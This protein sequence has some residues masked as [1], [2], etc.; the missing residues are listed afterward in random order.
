MDRSFTTCHRPAFHRRLLLP[1]Y[2]ST[3]LVFS[4]LAIL[5]VM[6]LWLRAA[7]ARLASGLLVRLPSKRRQVALTNLTTCFPNLEAAEVQALLSRHVRILCE[8]YLN[9]GDLLFGSADRLRRRFDFRGRE[10]LAVAAADGR[11]VIVMMPHCCA[12]EFGGQALVLDHPTVSMA[13]LHDDDEAMDWLITRLRTRFG[14]VVFGNTQSMVPVIRA[15]R[16]G[17]QMFYLPDE[18]RNS[19]QAVFVPF[20]GVAKLTTATV[21]RL[22]VACRA[23]VVPAICRYLPE[24]RRFEVAFAPAMRGLS[25]PDAVVDAQCV[26]AAIESLLEPDP[27]QYAW[28]QKIF[29]SRPPGEASVYPWMKTGRLPDA[30]AP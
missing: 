25:R 12:F 24:T 29:R 20:Y 11:G 16:D 9:Y 4:G 21:G 27:A 22:A 3:W 7:L 14:G 19:G 26:N 8:V 13:R 15:V 28:I 10:H 23:E 5:W 30:E 6:P 18:D 2:W 17:C 1:R